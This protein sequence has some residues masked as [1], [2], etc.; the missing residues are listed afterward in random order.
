MTEKDIK[1]LINSLFAVLKKSYIKKSGSE[2][3]D[4][5]IT[6]NRRHVYI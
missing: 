3:R 6:V 4:N 1:L 2:R 5:L